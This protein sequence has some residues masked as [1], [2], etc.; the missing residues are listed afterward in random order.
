MRRS[1]KAVTATVAAGQHGGG[2]SRGRATFTPSALEVRLAEALEREA[3][4]SNILHVISQSPRDVQPVFDTIA[5]AALKLCDAS[6][7]AVLTFDGKLMRLGALANVSP[8]ETDA[9]R[10]RYPM[11][12]GRQTAGSRAILTGRTVVVPDV[13]EDPEFEVRAR[14]FR[15]VVSVPLMREG[16][17]IGAITVGRPE[18]GQF[19]DHQIA[20]LQTFA[21]QAVIA[22]ENVR[23]FNAVEDRNRDL[24]IALD[25]QTATSEILRVISSTQTDLGPVFDTIVRAAVRLSGADYSVAARFD[26]QMLHPLAFHG[27][28]PEALVLVSRMFPMAPIRNNMLARAALTRSVVVI[29]DMLADSDYDQGYAQVGGWRSGC[30]VPM[31]RDGNLVGVIGIARSATGGFP[32]HIIQ[33]LQT[34]ADQAVIAIENVRLFNETK[35]ALEQQTAISEILRVISSSPTDVQPMLDAVVERAAKLCEAANATVFLAEGVNYRSAARFGSAKRPLRLGEDIPLTRGSATGRAIIDRTTIHLEDLAVVPENE[36]PVGRQ[37][38]R[39]AHTFLAVP[40]MREDRAIGAFALFRTEIRPFTEKQ[41]RLVKTFADQAAIAIENVRLFNETKEALEQQTATSE[42]LRVISQSPRNVQPVFDAIVQSAARLF[43]RKAA[44]RT[45]E[46][47]GVRRR[48]RSY[49]END[50]FHGPDVVPINGESLIGRVVLECRALQIADTEAPTTPPSTR[51]YADKLAFRA[52]ASAPLVRDGAA[53]GVISVSSKEPRAMSDKQM[54]L[55]ATFADQAVIAIENVRLFKELEL[56]TA[57]LTRSVGELKALGEVGQAVSSTLDLETVLSTI[58]S[59][60]TQL[61]GMDGG[62]IWEYH[63]AREQFYLH[64]T[65]GLPGELVEV[66]RTTPIRK[67]E[68]ALGRLAISGEPVEIHDMADERIYQ[69]RFREILIRCGYRSM[70]AVPL[71]R[72]DHLLGA[73]AVTRH[74]AGEF[75]PEVIT[76]LK[77]FATQSALAI[78]NARLFRE[79]EIK[80]RELET[81]SRHKSEFLANMSHELRTPLNA[82]IGF[83]EVLSERMFGD[84]NEKQAEYI[85]DILQSGQHL[86]SLINDILDLSKIEAGRMELE[87][88]EFD[89][90]GTIENTLTLVRERA[91]RRGITLGRS[92]DERLGSIRADERKVKQ[93]LLNL[94][95]NA[96]KFTPEGGKIDVRRPSMMA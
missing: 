77:T 84:I 8:D 72:E 36:Y 57:E 59:R 34:F 42:I 53:I 79:L 87:L 83:S 62:S 9:V 12:P 81:A 39:S 7:A 75:A 35:E 13:L 10:L 55:L 60:A 92:V 17:P 78:Q 50:E 4:T 85:S 18:P 44:L 70:L 63:E 69:S 29:P 47:D 73:L 96:L 74:T 71:L 25:K 6:S 33:L 80:S 95:S 66:F 93:V 46:G 2:K 48:A 41:I 49:A 24:T 20:L 61:A 65:D 19:P 58:V 68:G 28:S 89:L 32:D 26:G 14:I 56:R 51:A 1:A 43:G 86:L 11:P 82:I 21:D 45:V 5:A 16:S 27:F 37:L 38:Q 15:S 31:I 76:L 22:I 52:V 23:L 64:A 30:A 90:P 3:A 91:V 54:A 88:S 94:L 40:L 67:G